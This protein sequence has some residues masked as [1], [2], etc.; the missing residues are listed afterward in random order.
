MV[1]RLNI[2]IYSPYKEAGAVH[3]E[4]FLRKGYGRINGGTRLL[5]MAA[6]SREATLGNSARS[7]STNAIDVEQTHIGEWSSTPATRRTAAARAVA[8]SCGADI[9]STTAGKSM[10][11]GFWSKRPYPAPLRSTPLSHFPTQTL[12]S[13][14]PTIDTSASFGVLGFSRMHTAHIGGSLAAKPTR[15]G[16]GLYCSDQSVPD[17]IG[18]RPGHDRR[19]MRIDKRQPIRAMVLPPIPVP[20]GKGSLCHEEGCDGRNSYYIGRGCVWIESRPLTT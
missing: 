18:C 11:G 5:E 17:I 8:R 6:D 10:Y 16:C 14:V 19:H 12:L 2:L 9:T 3:V 4:I 1:S 20:K 7:K 13:S 15:G